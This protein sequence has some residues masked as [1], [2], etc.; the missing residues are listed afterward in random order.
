ML[1]IPVELKDAIEALGHPV[2]IKIVEYLYDGREATYTELLRVTGVRK[3]SLTYHLDIL[4]RAAVVGAWS[5]LDGN[6]GDMRR[7][8]YM[9]SPWG[10]EV[11]DG[12][13]SNYYS[14]ISPEKVAPRIIA[15]VSGGAL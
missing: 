11:I 13:I 14:M 9:L 2:R 3:G 12:L 5:R 6:L 15:K 8:G 7:A 4:T 10:K 1:E